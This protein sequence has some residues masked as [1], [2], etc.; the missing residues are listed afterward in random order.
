[1]NRSYVGVG[2]RSFKS[3]LIHLLETDYRLVGSRRVLELLAQDVA[4][5]AVEFHPAQSCVQSGWL[6]FTATKATGGKAHPGKSAGDY[7]LVTLSW[8]VVLPEDIQALI[9]MP[10]G[11]EGRRQRTQL[12]KKRLQRL[13]EY[14]L[15]HPDGPALLT[16]ADLGL[17]LGRTTSRISQLLNELRHQTGKSLLTKGYYFDQGLRPSHKAQ[18]IALYE[19]GMDEADIAYHT[20]HAQSS[21][22]RYIRDYERVKLLLRHQVSPEEI[23][24]MIDMQPTVVDAYVKLINQYHPDLLPK[25]DLSPHG[26]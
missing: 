22:G 3:A 24:P 23:C 17:M 9:N 19:Q 26:T 11:K 2:Q 12:L 20:Q 21:V 8:P 13:I 25:L 15:D 1:M 10:P 18:V 7:P 14:G 6:V 4:Q 5:L 16:T